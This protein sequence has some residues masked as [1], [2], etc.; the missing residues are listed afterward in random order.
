MA[1]VARIVAGQPRG[2]VARSEAGIA[3]RSR[4]PGRGGPGPPTSPADRKRPFISFDA[5]ALD[6][7]AKRPQAPL[8]AGSIKSLVGIWKERL[9]L[10]EPAEAGPSER[11]IWALPPPCRP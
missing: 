5:A 4:S 8:R 10:G 3:Q 6:G 2:A 1:L 7:S 9:S 11:A